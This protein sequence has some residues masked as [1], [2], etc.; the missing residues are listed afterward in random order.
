[1]G[2]LLCTMSVHGCHFKLVIPKK[3]NLFILHLGYWYAGNLKLNTIVTNSVSASLIIIIWKLDK[4]DT[5][6][7][8]FL[9]ISTI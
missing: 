8:L 6:L 4:L 7:F 9:K 2:Q 1:M 3:S 5:T